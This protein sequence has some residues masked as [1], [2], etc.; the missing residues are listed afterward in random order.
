VIS[1]YQYVLPPVSC[2]YTDYSASKDVPLPIPHYAMRRD[3]RRLSRLMARDSSNW[4]R[5]RDPDD[6]PLFPHDT[7]RL[8]PRRRSILH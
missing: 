1:S 5:I 7:Q 2:G 6:I 8:E 3:L 4:T